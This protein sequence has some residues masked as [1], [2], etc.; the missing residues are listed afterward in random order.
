ME[1][2]DTFESETCYFYSFKASFCRVLGD[3]MMG[4]NMAVKI[5][6]EVVDHDR[7]EIAI[8]KVN[9]WLENYLS[10]AIAVHAHDTVAFDM[11]L[12]EHNQ[13]RLDNPLMIT[14]NEPT[15]AY[16][17][18][19]LQAK[20]EAIADEVFYISSIEGKSDN[21]D[22]LEVV[23]MGDVADILPPM[24]KWLTGSSWFTEPWWNRNDVSMIDSLMP[25]G[26]DPSIRPMWAGTFEF[27]E[28]IN[29]TH[30]A[31]IIVGDF[32]P[33]IVE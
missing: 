21:A 13:P 25:E 28:N 4:T 14:P 26:A 33:K 31:Q 20:I 10:R 15:D 16:M 18:V 11:L 27:L 3:L 12:D 1:E 22:G 8:T 24:E 6:I 9:H 5:G 7:M 32:T 2:D 17:M 30:P 23:Y 19:L 29:D